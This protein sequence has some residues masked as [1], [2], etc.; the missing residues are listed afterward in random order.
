MRA[1][2]SVWMSVLLAI[3]F[4]VPATLHSQGYPTDPKSFITSAEVAQLAAKA[5]SMTSADKPTVNLPLLYSAPYRVFVEYHAGIGAAAVHEADAEIMIVVEGSGTITTGGT[6]IKPTRTNPTNLTGSGIEG[7]ISRKVGKGDIILI[8]VGE[9]HFWSA[10]DR[11]G[12]V[13][14][15]MHMPTP[16]H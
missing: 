15:S 16:A 10:V 3:T 7:G 5:K 12:L 4:S 1:V 9:P 6:L 2:R 14:V 8:S 13:L 11:G